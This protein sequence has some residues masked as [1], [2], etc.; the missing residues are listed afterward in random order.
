MTV[1]LS[2]TRG[3]FINADW[4][5]S[6]YWCLG[7]GENIQ[8]G[9]VDGD[10]RDDLLCNNSNSGA[11]WVDLAQP[12]GSFPYDNWMDTLNYCKSPTAKMYMGKFNADGRTDILC[13]DRSAALMTVDLS[14]A[15]GHFASA[16]W[17]WSGYWCTEPSNT[18]MIGDV[19]GDGRDDLVCHDNVGG[20]IV[21]DLAQPDGSFPYDNWIGP[22]NFCVG[23]NLS[24]FLADMDGNGRADLVCRD[25]ATGALQI[26]FGGTSGSFTDV[27]FRG[28]FANFCAGTDGTVYTGKFK[29]TTR[30]DLLCN[31]RN[32]TISV[33]YSILP[34]VY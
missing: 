1:D 24:P 33:Q 13:N 28:P 19:N 6:G 17:T 10:G 22:G 7:S 26:A 14:D 20:S 21:V 30:T 4:T 8:I 11:L 34:Q 29:G 12:D 15:S 5:W 32:G 25:S 9:D 31:K 16:D 23:P 27:K 2:D 3:R 18:L